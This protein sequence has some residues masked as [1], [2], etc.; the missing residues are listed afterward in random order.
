MAFGDM[1]EWDFASPTVTPA[2]DLMDALQTATFLGIERR[3]LYNWIDKGQMVDGIVIGGKRR[4]SKAALTNF[5]YSRFKEQ[6][7]KTKPDVEN[8]GLR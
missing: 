5:I 6:Q 3:T 4:W 8:T 2:D 7:Q 1:V